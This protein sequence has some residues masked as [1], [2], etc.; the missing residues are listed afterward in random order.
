MWNTPRPPISLSPLQIQVECG[1][2]YLDDY[3]RRRDALMAKLTTLVMEHDKRRDLRFVAAGGDGTVSWVAEL[4]SQACQLAKTE[5]VPPIAVL[6]LGTGNELARVTGWGATYRG[7]SLVPFVRNVAEGRVVAVDSW[8]WQA[9]P[10][11]PDDEELLERYVTRGEDHGNGDRAGDGDEEDDD[12]GFATTLGTGIGQKIRSEEEPLLHSNSYDSLFQG[13][14]GWG[15]VMTLNTLMAPP[16]KIRTKT[17]APLVSPSIEVGTRSTSTDGSSSSLSD[18]DEEVNH[19]LRLMSTGSSSVDSDSERFIAT[20]DSKSHSPPGHFVNNSQMMQTIS[21]SPR[22]TEIEGED[23]GK[24]SRSVEDGEEN[25]GRDSDGERDGVPIPAGLRTPRKSMRY[26]IEMDRSMESSDLPHLPG[27]AF[28]P[29]PMTPPGTQRCSN[30]SRH[31]RFRQVDEVRGKAGRPNVGVVGSN[32]PEAFNGGVGSGVKRST[33]LFC[34]GGVPRGPANNGIGFQ[35]LCCRRSHGRSVGSSMDFAADGFEFDGINVDVDDDDGRTDEDDEDDDDDDDD[36]VRVVTKTSVCFFSVGFDASIAMQFHQFRER[37]PCCADSVPKIVAGH[38]WLG[39]A[40]LFSSRKYLRPGVI[41]LRVDGVEVD[42]PPA[43]RTVQCFNI[44][45]SA[46]GIN[47]FGDG[48]SREGEL[49]EYEPPN[50]GDGL[51]EVVATYGVGHLSAIRLGMGHSHR[52]AQGKVV[53]I[54]LRESQPVQVDGEPWL[55]P[56]AIIVL[57]PQGKIPFVLGKGTTLN[58]PPLSHVRIGS[59]PDNDIVPSVSHIRRKSRPDNDI[60]L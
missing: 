39:I 15:S 28:A 38:A 16:P 48:P 46:T 50:I 56:P 8:L 24:E 34:G 30:R 25:G 40:E 52:L 45:S 3:L 20:T 26:S 11:E 19:R 43:A 32:S 9:T 58:V 13:T 7:E 49:Q 60:A 1:V 29:P 42:I 22:V 27:F 51:V 44:H 31:R 18:D 41:T 53:E 6:S 2:I 10:L 55:Q 17:K 59:R 21:V 5:S 12:E 57:S 23:C 36:E 54:V 14:T 33:S 47:F 35:R 37:T 4:V